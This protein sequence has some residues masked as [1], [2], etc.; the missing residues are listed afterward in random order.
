[1]LPDETPVNSYLEN[2]KYDLES[3]LLWSGAVKGNTK[4]NTPSASLDIKL[5]GA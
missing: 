4:D 1:M 5:I 2:G 3:K